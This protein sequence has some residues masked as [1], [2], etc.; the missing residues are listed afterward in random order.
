MTHITMSQICQLVNG[1][2]HGIE[3]YLNFEQEDKDELTKKYQ[4]LM[5]N[6]L[7]VLALLEEKNNKIA[8]AN[9]TI[10]N[11]TKELHLRNLELRKLKQK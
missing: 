11:L 9:A 3:H 4:I 6:H 2:G 5:E 10:V 1:S 8:D 7:Y